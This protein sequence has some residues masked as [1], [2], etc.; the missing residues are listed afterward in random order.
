MRWCMGRWVLLSTLALFPV[1][2]VGRLLAQEPA[3]HVL[4]E[5]PLTLNMNRLIQSTFKDNDEMYD[6][7]RLPA[8]VINP[9]QQQRRQRHAA[10]LPHGPM[11]RIHG[12]EEFM[13]RILYNSFAD[14]VD[15]GSNTN[16]GVVDPPIF[17]PPLPL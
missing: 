11:P 4:R 5:S 10:S 2:I 3:E 15:P 17:P 13:E 16:P 6:S 14:Y 1:L 7:K 9:Q 12:T 8:T